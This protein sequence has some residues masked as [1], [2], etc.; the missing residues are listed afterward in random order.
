MNIL[1]SFEVGWQYAKKHGLVVTLTLFATFVLVYWLTI[2]CFPEEFW[3]EYAK[4]MQS[5]SDVPTMAAKMEKLTPYM[6][7]ATSRIW[8]VNILQWLIIFGIVNMALS[9]VIGE[10]KTA[11]IKYLSLPFMTY[12]RV[13]EM[14]CLYFILMLLSVAYFFGLPYIYF[15]IRLMFAFP[16]MLEDPQCT[17]GTAIRQSWQMTKGRFLPML[18]FVLLSVLVL[19]IGMLC[20]FVGVFFAGTIVIYAYLSIYRQLASDLREIATPTGEGNL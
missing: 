4:I 7:E 15:G 17:V 2:Q 8:I 19:F 10:T 13:V 5:V 16:L 9:V 6:E 20:L 12:L 11:S 3:T 18:A 1:D 14:V